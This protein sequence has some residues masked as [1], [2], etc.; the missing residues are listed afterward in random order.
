MG[1][2]KNCNWK[3]ITILWNCW[4][5]DMLCAYEYLS[6][7]WRTFSFFLHGGIFHTPKCI[8]LFIVGCRFKVPQLQKWNFPKRCTNPSYHLIH[9]KLQYTQPSFQI[10]YGSLLFIFVILVI[11]TDHT[12]LSSM[13]WYCHIHSTILWHSGLCYQFN[14]KVKLS[15]KHITLFQFSSTGNQSAITISIHNKTISTGH[16]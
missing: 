11:Y 13:L 4:A 15:Y 10:Y 8:L 16:D 7:G 2:F 9:L 3:N 1:R 5:R 12:S 6:Q 14:S